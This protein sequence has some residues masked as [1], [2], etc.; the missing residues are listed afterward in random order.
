MTSTTRSGALGTLT[1]T[2]TPTGTCTQLVGGNPFQFYFGEGCNSGAVYDAWQCWPRATS[3]LA[4]PPFLGGGFYSPGLV[5]PTGYT[6]ACLDA[7]DD[8]G[9][10][11]NLAT[12]LISFSF[13][14]SLQV[15]E[16]ALGC[17]PS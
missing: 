12:S 6:T 15:G 16:T 5:C 14:Y 1:T 11:A 4:T 8:A 13:Q 3:G 7:T 17:C 9:Q 2:F 10:A